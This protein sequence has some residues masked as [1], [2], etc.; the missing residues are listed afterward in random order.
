MPN[1]TVSN[2]KEVTLLKDIEPKQTNPSRSTR[3]VIDDVDESSNNL[4][5]SAVFQQDSF[6]SFKKIINSESKS[7]RWAGH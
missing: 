5:K 2:G 6:Q 7:I 1:K 4:N 3:S